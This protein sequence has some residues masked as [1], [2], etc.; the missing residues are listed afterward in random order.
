MRF[1]VTANK[2]AG[3][4]GAIYIAK[5]IKEFNPS[6]EKK[7]VLGLPTGSTP[8]QMYKRLI[9]FNKEGIISFKN[10]ITFLKLIIPSLLNCINLLYI[11]NGVLP[12]GK[13]KTNF[14]SGLGL[15]SLI[16]FTI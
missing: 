4:W 13:P 5:K 16:F 15:N 6:P 7:F 8:L 10:V 3:D 14:F 9:Q 12:V 2:R 11:C 1:I